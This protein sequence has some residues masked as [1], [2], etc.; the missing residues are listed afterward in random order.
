MFFCFS[1]FLSFFAD[2]TT[3][4]YLFGFIGIKMLLLFGLVC[5]FWFVCFL[6]CF[7]LLVFCLL[8]CCWVLL[9]VCV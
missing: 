7:L 5:L 3:A 8:V 9:F 2:V 1:F 4:L 6:F